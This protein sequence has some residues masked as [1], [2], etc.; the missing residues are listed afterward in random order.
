MI[1]IDSGV[2]ALQTNRQKQTTEQK[3]SR[4]QKT[5]KKYD[6]QQSD[7]IIKVQETQYNTMEVWKS[8]LDMI[9]G[10]T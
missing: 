6:K 10:H 7:V 3:K 2:K 9:F 8:K 1:S 5:K 4:Q